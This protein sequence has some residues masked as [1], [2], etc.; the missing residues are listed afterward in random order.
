MYAVFPTLLI[1]EKFTYFI[2][3]CRYIL[4]MWKL[5]GKKS[6]NGLP[7]LNHNL[8]FESMHNFYFKYLNQG[9]VYAPICIYVYINVYPFFFESQTYLMSRLTY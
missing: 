2:D 7:F 3:R 5:C 9:R 8:F 1:L 6:E 4:C